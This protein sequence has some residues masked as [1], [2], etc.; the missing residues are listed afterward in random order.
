MRKSI[1]VVI[2]AAPTS[3]SFSDLGAVNLPVPFPRSDVPLGDHGVG[4]VCYKLRPWRAWLEVEEGE[5]ERDGS[6][7]EGRRKLG[8]E[9]AAL[10]IIW[11]RRGSSS[12]QIKPLLTWRPWM[13]CRTGG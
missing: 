8:Q 6:G 9:E 5:G 13:A 2:L 10:G 4:S 7:E 1:L 3:G 11:R 12:H